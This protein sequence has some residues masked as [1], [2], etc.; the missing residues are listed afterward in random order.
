MRRRMKKRYKLVYLGRS[1]ADCE[2]AGLKFWHNADA[3][4]KVQAMRELVEQ[5]AVCQGIRPHALRLLR[6]TALIRRP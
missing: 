3:A 2:K 5:T 4:A 6:T 1:F